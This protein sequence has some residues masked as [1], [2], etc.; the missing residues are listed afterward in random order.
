MATAAAASETAVPFHLVKTDGVHDDHGV[1][2]VEFATVDMGAAKTA[3]EMLDKRIVVTPSSSSVSGMSDHPPLSPLA[4]S[5]ALMSFYSTCELSHH[6]AHFS[7]VH[8]SDKLY[9]QLEAPKGSG[10]KRASKTAVEGG[11]MT[12]GQFVALVDMAMMLE[13]SELILTVKRTHPHFAMVIRTLLY[14]GFNLMPRK[15]RMSMMKDS[16]GT[17]LLTLALGGGS[18][19]HTDTALHDEQDASLRQ[20]PSNVFDLVAP[21]DFTSSAPLPPFSHSSSHHSSPD[22]GLLSSPASHSHCSFS[23]LDGGSDEHDD[24]AMGGGDIDDD[25]AAELMR[26]EY[27]F[28]VAD[29][30]PFLSFEDLPCLLEVPAT[31]PG[32]VQGLV[33]PTTQKL[34]LKAELE[35]EGLSPS[36]RLSLLMPHPNHFQELLTNTHV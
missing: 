7:C 25:L 12:K 27:A 3:V 16:R 26:S 28:S 8:L 15:V 17:E 5:K 34:A 35:G 11:G 24:A 20:S 1:F 22:S 13:A 19:Q 30:D 6:T 29:G 10:G 31:H 32:A 9:A 4:P 18:L 2:C 36:S 33:S 21:L 14:M 23:S